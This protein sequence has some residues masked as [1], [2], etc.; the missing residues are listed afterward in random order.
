M[1]KSKSNAAAVV[2]HERSRVNAPLHPVAAGKA[3]RGAHA[4]HDKHA[5]LEPQPVDARRDDEFDG[6]APAIG[7]GAQSG[8]IEL[9][10]E[11]FDLDVA[12]TAAGADRASPLSPRKAPTDKEIEEG[13]GDSML[14]E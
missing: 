5:P 2:G 3:S 1:S 11:E 13:G 7:P 12:P 10:E 6:D 4:K 14:A 8:D 9:I